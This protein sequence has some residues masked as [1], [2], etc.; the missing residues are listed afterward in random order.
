LETRGE[1]WLIDL[2]NHIAKQGVAAWV[3]PI[4]LGLRFRYVQAL[5]PNSPRPVKVPQA[6][7]DLWVARTTPPQ[8]E[9]DFFLD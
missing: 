1:V 3:N 9:D 8:P 6:V 2:E 5:K 4:S 7:F